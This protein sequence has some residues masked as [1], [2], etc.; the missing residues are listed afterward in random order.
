M[1]PAALLV[2]LFAA[3]SIGLPVAGAP[4]VA[5]QQSSEPTALERELDAIGADFAS[6]ST[7]RLLDRMAKDGTVRLSLGSSEGTYKRK[8]AEEVLDA[9]FRAREVLSVKRTKV[10]GSTGRFDLKFRASRKGTTQERALLVTVAAVKDA[11]YRLSQI[12]VE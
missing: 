6:E 5:A 9:W 3:A 2:V 8:Q 10:T 7:S 12:T 1:R 4:P 11:T